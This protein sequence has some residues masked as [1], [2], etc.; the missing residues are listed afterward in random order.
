MTQ[1][2]TSAPRPE[3]RPRG[4]RARRIIIV[5]VVL[6][7]I[8]TAADFGAAAF[9]EHTVS[10]KTREQFQLTE[11]PAV[12][13]H[14]FPFLTQ[15]LGGEYGHIS[16]SAAGVPIQDILRDVELKADLRDVDAPLSDLMGGRV[17]QVKIGVLEGSV[18]IKDS[19]IARVEPLTKIE[20]LRIDPA[21]EDYVRNG[22]S[23][24][25]APTTIEPG[26]EALD[27]ASAG[28]RM[29]GT[30]QLAGEKLELYC[31]AMIELDGTAIHITPER[32]QFGN[33]GETTIV[34]PQV[35]KA[36]LPNFKATVDAGSLPFEVTPKA[37][38][39]EQGAVILKG[40]A[41]NV[42]FA[43]AGATA[44]G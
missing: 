21:D 24:P 23:D 42:T 31:F 20:N 12:T 34:P 41:K 38:R 15:A 28:V 7:A 26:D 35:Q 16:L 37:V 36:L 6:A 39:V 9:A 4:R 29:S 44:G 33:D 17:E 11:D 43:G 8:L 14:G 18:K 32:L 13:V 30:L 27:D 2:D 22:G 40:E 25:E 19:D 5:V 1:Y 3:G 10:Q